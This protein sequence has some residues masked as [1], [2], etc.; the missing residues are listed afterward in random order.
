[1]PT[2]HIKTEQIEA[3]AKKMIGK[4]EQVP[5]VFSAKKVDGKRAYESARKGKKIELKP[6]LIEIKTF[7]TDCSNLPEIA[8]NIEC[9]KGTY[10]RSVA[11]DL[12]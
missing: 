8:F 1:M 2:D 10:I 6:N 11:R 12:G 5:P 3:F 7:E 4:Q 9:C